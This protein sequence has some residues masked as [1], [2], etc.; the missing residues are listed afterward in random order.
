MEFTTGNIFNCL[1]GL[2]IIVVLISVLVGWLKKRSENRR[3][4]IEMYTELVKSTLRNT[5]EE[6]TLDLIMD[7]Y[8]KA[9]F[10]LEISES[11]SLDL[12]VLKRGD[13]DKSDREVELYLKNV[14]RAKGRVKVLNARRE[15]FYITVHADKACWY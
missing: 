11:N 15:D 7:Y 5:S 4:R 12:K 2:W 13:T 6:S 10:H 3:C 14:L 8:R 9:G 1:L